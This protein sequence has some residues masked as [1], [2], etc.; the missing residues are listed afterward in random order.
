MPK[1][2]EN[3][4]KRRD[5]RWEGRYPK[6]DPVTGIARQASVYGK[7]YA[8][9]KEKLLQH[10]QQTQPPN[11]AKPEEIP[12]LTVKDILLLWLADRQ[13]RVKPSSFAR[14]QTLVYKQ[15]IPALGD[16]ALK[17]LTAQ[18]LSAFIE[19]KMSLDSNGK[20]SS[21]TIADILSVLKSA[22]KIAARQYYL[23]DL[24]SLFDVKAPVYRQRRIET[25][26][27]NETKLITRK[28][29][30][31]PTIDNLAILL[32]LNT[33]LRLGELCALRWEDVDF[34][35]QTLTVR[36]N[37]QRLTQN[38]KSELVIQ[39]PKSETSRRTIPLTAEILS[40][41]RTHCS[42]SAYVFGG[43][44]PLEPRTMQYRFNSFLKKNDLKVRNFHAL[45]HSF[46]TRCIAM[47]ADVKT[48]SEILGHSNIKTTMQL[49]VHPTMEQK[50]ANMQLV[51][52]LNDCA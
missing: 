12:K 44:K 34:R 4:Y 22:L 46:A 47:G 7:T 43:T 14:Y 52:T 48:L 6:I 23:P 19:K 15:L 30:Q 25:F 32:C 39:T 11:T 24:N 26:S 20:L 31:A 3:I 38:G 27:D 49:Y 50:R 16:I 51:S 42:Q 29:L 35:E 28:V 36:Q 1:R 33:G 5:G 17:D 18:K 41:L 21:K 9:V 10:R 8:E 2:G 40:L 37:V 45:R 13:P